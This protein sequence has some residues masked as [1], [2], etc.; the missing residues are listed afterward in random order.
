MN[1]VFKSMKYT[2]YPKN[3]IVFR[4]GDKGDLYYIILKGKVS[5]KIPIKNE[6]QM[7]DFQFLE[8]ILADKDIVNSGDKSNPA[9]KVF[10]HLKQYGPEKSLL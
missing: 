5:V 7:N 2:Q 6:V 1:V 3:H 9:D 8:M 4:Y 10:D